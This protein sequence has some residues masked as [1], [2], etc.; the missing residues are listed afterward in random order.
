MTA[1]AR[2]GLCLLLLA[3]ARP[4][5]AQPAESPAAAASRHFQRAVELYNDGDFRGALVEFNKAH[6][7][8]PRASVL[9]DI[10]QTE[11][12]LQEYAPALRTLERFLAETGPSAA[13][14]A[15]V[16]E[17]VQVL[18]GRV[19]HLAIS[20]DRPG[21]DVTIDEQAAGPT[22]LPE[23]VLVSVGRRR[24]TLACPG[25]PRQTRDV[26]VAAGETV[27]VELKGAPLAAAPS[28]EEAPAHRPGRRGLTTAWVVTAV[29]A[30]ATA[31]VYTAA[32]LQARKLDD[33]RNS[34][35]LTADQFDDKLNL[36]SRLALTGDILAVATVAAAGLSTYLT[37]T[38][39]EERA[40]RVGLSWSPGG[41]GVT[42]RRTF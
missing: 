41:A 30:G 33:L 2:V 5:A 1:L 31:A 35:P 20:S 15:E 34:Y 12:Q 14:R 27:P 38:S 16:Q 25:L 18:R 19:G 42:L 36:T 39:R 3:L 29:L 13:H 7:L 8:L 26:E 32:A 22:P 23:P 28:A 11:Y 21:C 17:T 24:V 6:T 10:G 40:V 37:L 4:A 9:Y